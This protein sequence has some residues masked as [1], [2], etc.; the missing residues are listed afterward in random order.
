M[1]RSSLSF[2]QLPWTGLYGLFRDGALKVVVSS[3]DGDFVPCAVNSP[4]GFC[5]FPEPLWPISWI[6]GY[7]SFRYT[8]R[9]VEEIVPERERNWMM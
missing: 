5:L 3:K 9:M 2:Q 4:R 1:P 7:M 6:L 8:I